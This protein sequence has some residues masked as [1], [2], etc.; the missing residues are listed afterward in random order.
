MLVVATGER[1]GESVGNEVT[2]PLG[3][4]L[5]PAA[6]PLASWANLRPHGIACL[7]LRPTQG[8]LPTGNACLGH[9]A[10]HP[11]GRA[12]NP[13]LLLRDARE[14]SNPSGNAWRDPLAVVRLERWPEHGFLTVPRRRRPIGGPGGGR[15]SWVEGRHPDDPVVGVAKQDAAA[16]VGQD[17]AGANGA[18]VG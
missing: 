16:V 2:V 17:V 12:E 9:D 10:P 1:R 3:G 11:C 4:C 14:S 13:Y 6:Q 18:P 8:G 15:S 5:C 7:R